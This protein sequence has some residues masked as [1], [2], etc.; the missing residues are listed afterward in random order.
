MDKRAAQLLLN[1]FP[2]HADFARL[3]PLRSV[4]G[5]QTLFLP[6]TNWSTNSFTSVPVS[7]LPPGWTLATV[8]V[9]GIQSTSSVFNISVTPAATA[10]PDHVI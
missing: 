8:F 7:G 10:E 3:V 6:T 1:S 5:G 9:N 4:E 2:R